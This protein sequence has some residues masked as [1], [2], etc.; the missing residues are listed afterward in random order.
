MAIRNTKL[1]GSTTNW[2]DESPTFQDMNATNDAII[3][4]VDKY[5]K[6]NTGYTTTSGTETSLVQKQITANDVNKGILVIA[7]LVTRTGSAAANG[8]ATGTFKLYAGTS[9][10]FG[11][12]TNWITHTATII[13]NGA[14]SWTRDNFQLVFYLDSSDLTYTSLNYLDITAQTSG[15]VAATLELLNLTII[16]Y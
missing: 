12:N 5:I 2:G 8:D 9:A 4:G 7:S 14:S 16:K 11:S 10:T 1:K 3:D 13:S 6:D 15:T